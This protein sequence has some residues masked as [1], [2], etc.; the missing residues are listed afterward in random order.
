M[1]KQQKLKK[2]LK[3]FKVNESAISIVLG[4]LVI[5]ALGMLVYNYFRSVNR[6]KVEVS[7]INETQTTP[8]PGEVSKELPAQYVIAEGD[9]LWKISEKFFDSGYNWVDIA[10]ANNLTN[11]NSLEAG[12][13]LVIPNVEAIKP[14]IKVAQN[15]TGDSIQD[16]N[17]TVLKGDHLWGIAVRAYGDG[18]KWVE[19][20]RANNLTNPGI[21]H[22]GTVLTLPR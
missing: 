21:I 18:Y 9:N 17:Y 14:E 3:Q 4:G 15:N 12:K 20:A 11:P 8:Q 5:I 10:K 22:V 7:T 13:E 2:G 16:E 6:N 19:I 1:V